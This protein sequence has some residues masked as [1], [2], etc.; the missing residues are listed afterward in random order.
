MKHI[1]DLFTKYQNTL[2]PPQS[3]VIKEF[4]CACEEVSGYKIKEEQCSYTVSTKTIYLTVPSLL[5]TE[6][7]LQKNNILEE[8]KNRLDKNSPINII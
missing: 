3:A 6:L 4:V 1:G 2:K 7:L 8:L 5:K